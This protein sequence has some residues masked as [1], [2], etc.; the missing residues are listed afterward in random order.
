[1]LKRII[2]LLFFYSNLAFANINTD[3]TQFNVIKYEV[4]ILNWI[5]RFLPLN[6]KSIDTELITDQII[7]N[8]VIQDVPLDLLIGTIAVESRFNPNAAS[9]QGAKGIMQVVPRYHREK[10]RNRNIFDPKVGLEV[11]TKILSDCYEKAQRNR[12]R[13][14]S[15][16]SGYKGDQAL[17]YQRAVM[18]E[19]LKFRDFLKTHNLLLAS[20]DS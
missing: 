18:W 13:T 9:P 3:T 12:A 14:L 1:M 6:Q 19:S 16:Y 15:C 4:A 7:L 5:E 17:R 11:G 2:F 8:S 20:I 10:I